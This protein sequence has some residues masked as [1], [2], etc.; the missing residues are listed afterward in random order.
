MTATGDERLVVVPS[1]SWPEVFPPQQYAV[2]A[3]VNAHVCRPPAVAAV[4]RI[5][6]RTATGNSRRVETASPNCPSPLEPQQ[7][8]APALV[9]AQT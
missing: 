6:P 4:K 8:A 5:S 3:L 1:P 9:S 2:P 7:Y